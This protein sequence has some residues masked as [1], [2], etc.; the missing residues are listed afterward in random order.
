MVRS[1]RVDALRPGGILSLAGLPRLARG[2]GGIAVGT[3]LDRIPEDDA[4]FAALLAEVRA[5]PFSDGLL[6]SPDGRRA[7][8]SLP[9]AADIPAAVAVGE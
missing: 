9:L 5:R 2:R 7:L 3:T 4:G 8:F 6:L 1:W